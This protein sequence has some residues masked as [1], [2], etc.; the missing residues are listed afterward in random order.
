MGTGDTTCG[1]GTPLVG[2]GHLLWGMDTYCGAG[3]P[4]ME[5]HDAPAM[6]SRNWHAVP[7]HAPPCP[8]VQPPRDGSHS[9]PC[10]PPSW[11]G[12]P[13][14][15]QAKT[16][17]PS[18]VMPCAPCQGL[19]RAEPGEGGRGTGGQSTGLSVTPVMPRRWAEFARSQL[20]CWQAPRQQPGAGRGRR[21][22]GQGR[23]RQPRS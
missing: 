16:K 10:P 22:P 8:A 4:L 20:W 2:Q 11:P 23:R 7:C 21:E 5:H 14:G 15:T 3:M 13:T 9:P 1:V 12:A 19:A 18:L 6:P 17:I